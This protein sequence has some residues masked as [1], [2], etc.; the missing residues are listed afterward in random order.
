MPDRRLLIAI[1][2]D[3]A[4]VLQA[5]ER[6]LRS[7]GHQPRTYPCADEFLRSLESHRP[8]CVL[9]DLH[10]PGLSGFDVQARLAHWRPPIPVVVLT[11]SHSEAAGD[12][13]MQGGAFAILHK[14]ADGDA[15][16]STLERAAAP[17]GRGDSPGSHPTPS[18][19][20]PGIP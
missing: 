15:L 11:G 17:G 16:I 6:L 8:D 9:L 3:E 2:D 13:A 4:D 14:P 1:V 20:H 12:R 7:A 19:R 5:L 10:M 18:R